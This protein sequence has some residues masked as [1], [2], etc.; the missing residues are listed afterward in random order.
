MTEPLQA[1]TPTMAEVYRFMQSNPISSREMLDEISAEST[2]KSSWDMHLQSFIKLEKQCREI[3]EQIYDFIG[4]SHNDA[5]AELRLQEVSTNLAAFIRETRGRVKTMSDTADDIAAA[6]AQ[7]LEEAALILEEEAMGANRLIKQGR[8][9]ELGIALATTIMNTN[10]DNAHKIRALITPFDSTALAKQAE[11]N[12]LA[13]GTFQCDI[14]GQDT[15]HFHDQQL[16]EIE[17]L[18]RPAFENTT[19]PCDSFGRVARKPGFPYSD[20]GTER[21][22][23]HFISGWFASK[24]VFPTQDVA[25]LLAEERLKCESWDILQRLVEQAEGMIDEL[26]DGEYKG[27]GGLR[28]MVDEARVELAARVAE[29]KGEQG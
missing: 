23:Q 16:V 15:P 13:Q 28:I 8:G 21:L 12:A 22:W 20:A 5:D 24:S 14:C 29:L 2:P 7:A 3:A 18:I 11:D 6:R 27:L 4:E 17:R 9:T 19:V 25:K 1:Y 10:R 26:P